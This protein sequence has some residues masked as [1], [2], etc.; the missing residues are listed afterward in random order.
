MMLGSQAVI[1]LVRPSTGMPSEA[2]MRSMCGTNSD[3]GKQ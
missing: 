1:M 2:M 3:C